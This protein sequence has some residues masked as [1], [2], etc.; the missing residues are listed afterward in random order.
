MI[1]FC[2]RYKSIRVSEFYFGKCPGQNP[3]GVLSRG[4]CPGIVYNHMK[5]APRVS[6]FISENEII[7]KTNVWNSGYNTL[8]YSDSEQ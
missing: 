3:R 2:R 7:L 1:S 6:E 8:I 4:F 5:N